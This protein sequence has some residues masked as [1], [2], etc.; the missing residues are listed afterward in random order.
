MLH[1]IVNPRSG[2]NQ[3]KHTDEKVT[4]VKN[5]LQNKNV[6][7]EIL[8]TEYKG[9]AKK[10]TEELTSQKNQTIIVIG[11]DGTLH[12]VINGWQDFDT[13]QMGLIPS[14]TGN[15]FATCVGLSE[16]VEDCLDLILNT[17]A[18]Y[19]D[20]MQLPG[21]RCINVAG[22]GIDVEVLRRY[23][24]LKN[25]T[26]AGYAKC[27]IKTLFTYKCEQFK[28]KI[29][30][31]ISTLKSFIACVANGTMFGGG[32]RVCPEASVSDGELNF[33]A[34]KSMCKLKLPK[35]LSMLKKG[36]ILNHPNAIQE[37]CKK[38]KIEGL[39]PK[40]INCDGELYDNIPFEI[41]VVHD[42]LKMFRP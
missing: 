3:G 14:G 22:M 29:N 42:K 5:Y 19:T 4:A 27:L 25:K 30:G 1:F 34:I 12:E 11:G 10:M 38:I 28:S 16:N 37:K 9:H 8:C 15:D 13:C 41:E 23:E 24:S 32:L 7:F 26:K 2:G 36:T 31:A 39:T 20:F 6:E 33:V 17:N 21:I 18:K 35:A 40:T